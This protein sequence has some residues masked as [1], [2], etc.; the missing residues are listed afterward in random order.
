[1][2]EPREPADPLPAAAAEGA[3]TPAQHDLGILFVHGI[4][5]QPEGT[6]LLAFGEP[7]IQW[8]NRWLR[9]EA[10]NPGL[11]VS[12]VKTSLTP[13]KLHQQLPP[14]AELQVE[15]PP[16]AGAT[17]QSWLIAE[18]WW[19]GE[20]KAPAFGKLAGWMM[21]V[22]AWSLGSTIAAKGASA[23]RSYARSCAKT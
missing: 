17:A 19:S 1:M 22:G 6:T 16:G 8:L 9:R 20:V 23:Y 12:V 21:T 2:H 3:A 14:H 13:S 18:S 4:G 5:D 11:G 7:L 15:L 10:T